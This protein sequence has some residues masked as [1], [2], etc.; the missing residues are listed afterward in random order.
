MENMDLFTPLV[1]LGAAILIIGL[2]IA[3]KN[4]K[5]KHSQEL[6]SIWDAEREQTIDNDRDMV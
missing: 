4:G 2:M 5:W 3:Y 6:S 1:I